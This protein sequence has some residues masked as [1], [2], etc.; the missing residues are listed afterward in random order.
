MS[1]DDPVRK[2]DKVKREDTPP[3]ITPE[4]DL[5]PRNI[6]MMLKKKDDIERLERLIGKIPP[7]KQ[8]AVFAKAIE[9]LDFMM[10]ENEEGTI[11]TMKRLNEKPVVLDIF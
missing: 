7:H 2:K 5:K 10:Y 4:K 9:L 11:F 8:T 1:V 6:H 3:R